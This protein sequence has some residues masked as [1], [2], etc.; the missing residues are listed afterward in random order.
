MG[1]NIK[2]GIKGIRRA[3]VWS[4]LVQVMLQQ[5]DS[6]KTGNPLTSRV[7]INFS[8]TTLLHGIKM[9]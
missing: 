2:V 8:R 5:Q 3:V 7:S 9:E 1:D 6:V 4:K